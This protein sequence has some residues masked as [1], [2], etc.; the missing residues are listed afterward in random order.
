MLPIQI[1]M[2]LPKALSNCSPPFS[3]YLT[4]KNFSRN[5][6]QVSGQIFIDG[7]SSMDLGLVRFQTWAFKCEPRS[8]AYMI[9]SSAVGKSFLDAL[10]P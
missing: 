8:F 6:N 1:G 7:G 10:S 4:L 2:W 5:I 9:A 3:Y